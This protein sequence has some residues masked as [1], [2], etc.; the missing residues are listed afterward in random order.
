MATTTNVLKVSKPVRNWQ[1]ILTFAFNKLGENIL[2][3][4]ITIASVSITLAVSWQIAPDATMEYS[5]FIVAIYLLILFRRIVQDFDDAYTLDE[6][7]EQVK[8]VKDMLEQLRRIQ[9]NEYVD[10]DEINEL[11]RRMTQL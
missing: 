10:V 8:L 6:I 5:G 11:E 9:L 4:V 3:M 1:A 2:D 7:G